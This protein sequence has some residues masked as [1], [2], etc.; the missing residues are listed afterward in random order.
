MFTELTQLNEAIFLFPRSADPGAVQPNVGIIK[1]RSQTILIDAG[2]SPTHARQVLA[3]MAGYGFASVQTLIY[4]HHHWDHIFGASTYKPT[5]I[6]AHESGNALVAPLVDRDWSTPLLEEEI[7]RHP[8]LRVRNEAIIRAISNWYDFRV[9]PPNI[10]FEQ[11]MALHVDGWT[12]ELAHVGGVHAR[13]SIIIKIPQARIMF[14][15]DCYY[16]LPQHLRTAATD[17]AL[18]LDML[19]A[20]IDDAYDLYVDGHGDPRDREAFRAMI[21]A[22]RERQQVQ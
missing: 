3:A 14:L 18:A 20:L 8:M 17:D 10:T 7:Q 21:D 12:L 11:T 16:P 1:G 13:D 2:N 9:L 19:E 4:T 22:E 6:I 5:T 15:G